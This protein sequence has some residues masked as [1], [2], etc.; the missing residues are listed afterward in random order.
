MTPRP[1]SEVRLVPAV[2]PG[3]RLICVGLNHLNRMA[4]GEIV[5]VRYKMYAYDGLIARA[6]TELAWIADGFALVDE[7]YDS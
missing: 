2:P 1:V 5:A 6:R 7:L 3:A 4:D